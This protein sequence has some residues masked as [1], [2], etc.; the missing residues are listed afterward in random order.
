MK[1]IKSILFALF[2]IMFIYVISNLFFDPQFEVESSIE[3]ESSPY[4]VYEQIC[5]FEHWANWSPWTTSDTS[6]EMTYSN[7]S[8]DVG[9]Y[10]NWQSQNTGNG[11]IELLSNEF[12]KSLNYEIVID[13]N[14]PFYANFVLQPKS[15]N[16][17]LTW[18]NYGDLPFLGRIFGPIISKMIKSDHLSG[19]Q[20]LKD[21]CENLPSSSSEIK[22]VQWDSQHQISKVK[23]CSSQT[24]NTSLSNIYNDLFEYLAQNGIM[25]TQAPFAQYLEFPT[26]PNSN[27]QVKLR[28]GTFIDI[29]IKDSLSDEFEY[30]YTPST[31][32]VQCTHFGDYRTIFNTHE[33][34]K[35]YCQEHQFNITSTPYEIYL[36]DPQLNPN[37]KDWK[38]LVVYLIQ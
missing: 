38:T 6:I 36:T 34:I 10:M 37:P 30:I 21:Y 20:Q 33:K 32:S 1:Y 8:F 31:R 25:P 27:D 29:P 7:P 3:I 26:L 9:A 24:I 12:I 16:V 19:L 13:Q 14:P 28:A 17:F 23:K 35:L 18:K 2:G 22:V 11:R 15:K 5:N 4:V